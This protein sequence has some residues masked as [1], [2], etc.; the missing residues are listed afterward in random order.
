MY[1]ADGQMDDEVYVYGSF[2]QSKMFHAGVTCSDCH[3][4]H[5]L[6]LRE[7]GNA[8]CL[9]CHQATKYDQT[10]HH[11]HKAGSQGA[12]C[13]ECHMPPRTYMVVDP[14]TRSQYAHPA[15]GSFS[16]TRDAQRLQRLPR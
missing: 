7:P 9:Q 15:S 3:E 14:R 10:N 13:A 2:M 12:S 4:P 16:E 1:F 6:A 11:F 8:V 5:S